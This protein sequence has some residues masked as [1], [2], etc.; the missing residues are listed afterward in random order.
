MALPFRPSGE[1][2]S[3]CLRQMSERTKGIGAGQ[4]GAG[5]TLVEGDGSFSE[6][7]YAMSLHSVVDWHRVDAVNEAAW[8]SMQ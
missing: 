7:S 5:A 6:G 4:S 2:A 1:T 3:C 8:E